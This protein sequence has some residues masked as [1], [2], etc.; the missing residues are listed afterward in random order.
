MDRF[1]KLI[2]LIGALWAIDVVAYGG[3]YSTAVWEQ[4]NYEGQTVQ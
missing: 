2:V 3:R 4:A 1:I